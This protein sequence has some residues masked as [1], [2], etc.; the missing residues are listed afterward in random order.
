MSLQQTIQHQTRADQHTSPGNWTETHA[1]AANNQATC[2]HAAPA[3]GARHVVTSISASIVADGTAPTA[4]AVQLNLIGGTS[5]GTALLSWAMAIPAT[6]GAS[7][8]LTLSNLSIE[9]ADGTAVT[10]EFA[11]AGGGDTRESVALTGYTKNTVT[12]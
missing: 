10:L 8:I 12:S 4:A 11:A 7:C 6:A 1:P 5:G 9:I 2:T 3:S